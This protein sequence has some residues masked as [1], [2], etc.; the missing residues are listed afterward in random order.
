MPCSSTASAEVAVSP[1]VSLLIHTDVAHQ[2]I[3][4]GQVVSRIAQAQNPAPGGLSVPPAPAPLA[5]KKPLKH[6]GAVSLEARYFLPDPACQA[7]THCGGFVSA[8]IGTS[9]NVGAAIGYRDPNDS[10]FVPRLGVCYN[11][12]S[13]TTQAFFGMSI[14]WHM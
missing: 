13:H 6:V 3:V 8:R 11:W 2:N 14:E 12:R 9:G 1:N 4:I 7:G 5:N 10:W